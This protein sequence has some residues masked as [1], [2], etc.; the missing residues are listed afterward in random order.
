MST[1]P[2]VCPNCKSPANSGETKCQICGAMIQNST[3]PTQ[4]PNTRSPGGYCGSCGTPLPAKY[5]PCPSCGHVKTTFGAPPPPQPGS[6]QPHSYKGIGTCVA[7]A[8][9]P[10]F[11]GICGIGHFYINK[12]GRGI[13]CL[14]IGIIL[15][16]IA[17]ASMGIGLVAFIPFLAWT[18]YD[19]HKDT[20][21]YNSYMASHQKPPW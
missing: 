4:N 13:V 10:G 14:I 16:A 5:A 12:I 20:K 9:I 7:L 15:G 6:M 2:S 21:Y 3:N 17:L 11:F 19:A 18:V 1:S 8:L